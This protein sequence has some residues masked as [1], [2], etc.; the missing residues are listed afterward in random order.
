MEKIKMRRF[1]S[2]FC[3]LL[4]TGGVTRDRLAFRRVAGLLTVAGLVA[5]APILAKEPVE[6]KAK[7]ANRTTAA[8]AAEHADAAAIPECLE[9]LNLTSEQ[10][11]QVKEI[12]HNYDGSLGMVWK[13]F[14]A[15]YMQTICTETALMAAIEDNLSDAQR[16]QVRDQRRKTAQHEKAVAATDTKVNQAA[17]KPNEEA[18]K[19]GD[20]AEEGIVAAGVSLTDEQEAAAD[21][22]QEKYRAQLR[23]MNRDIQGLHTRLLSLEADKLVEIEKVLTK[24]QL[25]QLRAARMNPPVAM[26]VANNRAEPSKTE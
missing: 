3:K 16:Q 20:A 9:K 19:P 26:K 23:S 1:M 21:K 15:R 13:Q 17:V 6:G 8:E 25:T 14:S 5:L 10:Q 4:S 7:P 2:S 11:S 12:I 24:E 22:V 18:K